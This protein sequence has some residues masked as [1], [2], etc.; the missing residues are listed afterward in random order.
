[1]YVG[2]VL[3]KRLRTLCRL[4]FDEL[5]ASAHKRSFLGDKS[6]SEES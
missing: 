4:V 1:V 2:K 3:V 6:Y 5:T